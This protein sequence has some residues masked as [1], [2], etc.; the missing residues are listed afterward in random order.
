MSKT[1][2]QELAMKVNK[3]LNRKAITVDQIY[4]VVE[5]AKIIKKTKGAFG[6]FSFA[7]SIPSQFFTDTEIEKLKKSPQWEEFS[8]KMI[9]LF[10]K[11]GI[12]SK[13]QANMVKNYI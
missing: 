5:K 3:T 13:M 6:L 11:E 12:I 7:T 10:V 8:Q 2:Y 1:L 9:N 4:A